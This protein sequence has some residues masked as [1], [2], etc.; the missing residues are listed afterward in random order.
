[1]TTFDITSKCNFSCIYCCRDYNNPDLDFNSW[2]IILNKIFPFMKREYF[3]L[4]GG[5]PLLRKDILDIIDYIRKAYPKNDSVFNNL[6]T[7]TNPNKIWKLIENNK[8]VITTNSN[9]L[10]IKLVNKL[11]KRNVILWVSLD[12]YNN[13]VFKKIRKGSNPNIIKNNI[14]QFKAQIPIHINTV[15]I[16]QNKKD[17]LP[18]L[19]FVN[20]HK[21][22]MFRITPIREINKAIKNR[23]KIYHKSY[24]SVILKIINFYN[25]NKNLHTSTII[26]LH[27][28]FRVYLKGIG[29]YK[30]IYSKI[31]RTKKI[32]LEEHHCNFGKLKR[33]VINSNGDLVGCCNASSISFFKLDTLLDSSLTD[34]L[35]SNRLLELNQPPEDCKKCKYYSL[36]KGGCKIVS[37]QAS[38]RIDSIDIT[39]PLLK[40]V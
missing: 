7:E 13:K 23:I 3:V 24:H 34:C 36:C 31:Q 20:D 22:N 15:V 32:F 39:C 16:E 6:L 21:I 5:E 27:P 17:I 26:S 14:I 18:L 28:T 12:A 19:R 4:G 2:K 25:S 35:S 1:M 38:K 29:K 33:C 10:N 9:L 11:K 40:N 8:I 37:Y 30:E